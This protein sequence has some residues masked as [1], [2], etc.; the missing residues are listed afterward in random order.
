MF[1][2]QLEH[3]EDP[4]WEYWPAAQLVHSDDVAAPVADNAD[5]AAQKV[6]MVDPDASA[7]WPAAHP[8]QLL[9]SEAPVV[10]R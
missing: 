2:G 5:P 3:V 1:K 8:A 9:D 6:H 10:I 7:Y 4:A